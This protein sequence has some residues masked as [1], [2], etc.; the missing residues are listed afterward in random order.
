MLTKKDIDSMSEGQGF[1]TVGVI[2]SYETKTAKNGKPYMDGLIEIKGTVPFKVWQGTLFDELNTCDYSDTKCN[3]VGKVNEYNGSKS[4]IL[5]GVQALAPKGDYNI[6][7]FFESK[8]NITAYWDGLCRLIDKSASEEAFSV[9]KLAMT[10]IS[11]RFKVEF[12]ARSHHDAFMGGLLAHTYKVTSIL[13]RTM[14]LYPAITQAVDYDLLVIGAALHD[15]GKVYEYTNGSIIGN[16]LIVSHHTFGV[17]ILVPLKEQIVALKGEEFYYRL[18]A[19]IEQHHGEFEETPRA[20]E[21]YL[22][23]LAD[24]LESNCE[25]VSESIENGSEVINIDGFK[26]R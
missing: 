18:L 16:G 3:I 17:E 2:K 9:F 15:I 5:V 19:I 23:H 26:L 7:D 21:A 11:D 20:L 12:A 8:Y 24:N 14:K 6:E 4:A 10:G 1:E 13:I 25:A 22:V